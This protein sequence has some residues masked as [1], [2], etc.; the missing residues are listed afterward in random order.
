MALAVPS[1]S[2][3]FDYAMWLSAVVFALVGFGPRHRKRTRLLSYLFGALLFAGL[4]FQTSCGG[5]RSTDPGGSPGTPTGQYNIT[6]T[7]TSGSTQHSTSVTLEV[8]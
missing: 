2:S 4:L 3:G 7:A 8:E 5:G 1:N 6:I